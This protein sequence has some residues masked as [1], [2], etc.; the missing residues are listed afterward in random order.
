[1]FFSEG[2][3]CQPR[4]GE[5]KQFTDGALELLTQM[6]LLVG[7]VIGLLSSILVIVVVITANRNKYAN[8]MNKIGDHKNDR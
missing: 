2:D 4:C 5:F 6:A 8:I 7:A 3:Q 1:M